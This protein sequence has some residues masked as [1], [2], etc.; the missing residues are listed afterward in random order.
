MG[1]LPLGT[2]DGAVVYSHVLGAQQE[3]W[4]RG[5]TGT[6]AFPSFQLTGACP[7][8]AGI[9]QSRMLPGSEMSPLLM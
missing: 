8:C 6:S 4:E 9:G 2:S 5:G 1:V 7:Q 3:S